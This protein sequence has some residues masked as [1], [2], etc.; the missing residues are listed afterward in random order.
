MYIREVKKSSK[1]WARLVSLRN[2]FQQVWTLFA[3]LDISNVLVKF[4]MGVRTTF[5]NL[6]SSIYARHLK[7]IRYNNLF[8][9]G[10]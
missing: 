1:R 3:R 2:S 9:A 4:D 6:T 7:K 8:S 5:Y 10:N